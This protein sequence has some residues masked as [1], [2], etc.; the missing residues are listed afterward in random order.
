MP[1]RRIQRA[2]AAL[3]APTFPASIAFFIAYASGRARLL[4]LN[5]SVRPAFRAA[6]A[7]CPASAA[8]S[9]GGF[10]QK[11]CLPAFRAWRTSG[12][13]NLFGVI[14]L[15]ASRSARASISPTSA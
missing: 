4:K 14:T 11:T 3:I 12:L 13:W 5:I 7:I 6:A 8:F 15:T 9:A 1:V 2:W 10:S